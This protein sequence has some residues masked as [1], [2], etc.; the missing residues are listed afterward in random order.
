[1]MIKLLSKKTKS[2]PSSPS[3][4]PYYTHLRAFENQERILHRNDIYGGGPPSHVA[5]VETTALIKKYCGGSILDIGCGV[6]AYMNELNKFG[7]KCTG[8]EYNLQYVEKCQSQG[9]VVEHMN[10]KKLNFGD[11]SFDTVLMIEVLEHVE[12]PQ[13]ALMEAF[14]VSTLN[15]I[16]SVPNIDVL[17]IMSKYQVVP[18]H[19]L[20]ATHVNFFTP[21]ILDN[22]LK[23]ISA[24]T[25]VQT[26]GQFAPWVTEQIIHMH[27]LG[28]IH[29]I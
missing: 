6:G 29:K 25:T 1:M 13:Q 2:T 5:S 19:L 18:W 4:L 15:V 17:P 27:I 9:L 3:D 20:E 11:N 12:E 10:A 22:L 7:F 8:I 24:K 21:V 23:N 26:Y 28:V 14:R 16:I